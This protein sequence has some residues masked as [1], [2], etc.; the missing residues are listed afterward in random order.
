[1]NFRTTSLSAKKTTRQMSKLRHILLVLVLLCPLAASAIPDRPVPQ[2]LVNDF[3]GIFTSDQTEEL[4]ARLVA[5]DDSTSNQI[6]VVTVTDLEGYESAEYAYHIGESW[7]VGNGQ[8]DNGVVVLVVPKTES[9]GGKVSIQ[10]GYGLEGAIPDAYCK[11]I[12][13]NEMIPEFQDGNYFEGVCAAC[14][15]LMG[16][17]SGEISEP[18]EDKVDEFFDTINAILFFAFVLFVIFLAFKADK[19]DGH[20]GSGGGGGPYIFFGPMGGG[21]SSSSGDIFGGGGGSFGGGFGG[22]GGGSFGGGGASGSW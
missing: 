19:H 22:F 18:R 17:A 6:A 1:M 8:F 12:I 5:F 16:L 14:E 15:T 10:V 9:S 2:R 11:R 4:E 7:K 21:S 3:A 13:E 20:G